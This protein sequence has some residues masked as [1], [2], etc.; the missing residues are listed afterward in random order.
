MYLYSSLYRY[1]HAAIKYIL[2][3]LM[4]TI[5]TIQ[6]FSIHHISINLHMH[7]FSSFQLT[8]Y[9]FDDRLF[10][11]KSLRLL[12]FAMD[13]LPSLKAATFVIALLSRV[14][15]HTR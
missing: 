1:T 11:N 4:Y 5:L 8:A 10:A 7:V 13:I 3:I 6:R 15:M 12:A 2:S 9:L 14:V